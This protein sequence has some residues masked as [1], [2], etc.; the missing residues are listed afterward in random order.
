MVR[1]CFATNQPLS[2][3]NKGSYIRYG[4][5]ADKSIEIGRKGQTEARESD[6]YHT[7]GSKICGEMPQGKDFCPKNALVYKQ[8]LMCIV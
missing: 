4:G 1:D 8:E 3:E 6:S 7:T 2:G 5:T